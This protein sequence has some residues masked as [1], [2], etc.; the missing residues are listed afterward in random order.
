MQ[1]FSQKVAASTGRNLVPPGPRV[2]ATDAIIE[3]EALRAAAYAAAEHVA[4]LSK[5]SAIQHWATQPINDDVDVLVVDRPGWIT[6]NSY[7]LQVM[8][9][10]AF[11]RLS[12][13]NQSLMKSLGSDVTANFSGAQVGAVLAFLST[14]ILGQFEPYAAQAAGG[15]AKP[16]LMLV[17]P[18]VMMIRDDLKLDAE[19]FRF[20]VS[21]HELTHVAQFAQAPWLTQHVLDV[22]TDFLLT[23]ILPESESN[24]TAKQ[25]AA[26]TKELESQ[27]TGVM[28]LLEGHANV[29]MDAVDRKLV[30]SVRIIRKRF[31]DRSANHN[32][33]AQ[34]LRRLFGLDAKAKQ[35]KQG[36]A[37]VAAVVDRVGM[38]QFNVVW[39]APENLPSRDELTNADAWIA[40]VLS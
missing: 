20:W 15:D 16:R 27:I 14:K 1:I 40:R 29:I 21:L 35:Y 2:P 4:T 26:K 12:Q 8:L 32:W 28:S 34:L 17:A 36:Q 10:P 11:K 38:E 9:E 13:V 33:L 31:D 22:A 7:S 19:D 25:K 3:A 30:P 24:L 37:F 23:N 39:E 6:A 5:L 18:N